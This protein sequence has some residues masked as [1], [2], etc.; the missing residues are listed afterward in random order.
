MTIEATKQKYPSF[1]RVPIISEGTQ[2][3]TPEEPAS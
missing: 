3:E 2:M 1:F